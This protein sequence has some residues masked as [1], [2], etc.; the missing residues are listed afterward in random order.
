MFQKALRVL[1]IED[2]PDDVLL[3]RDFLA[4]SPEQI[5]ILH[6]E[7]L[8]EALESLDNGQT[9]VDAVLLD[10]G[11]P[12]TQG[13]ETFNQ[14]RRQAPRIP[15]V[16][17]TGM[18]DEE[19]ASQAVRAGAQDYLVKGKVNGQLL[20]RALY[21]AVERKKYEEAL[22]RA[23]DELESRVQ[24]RTSELHLAN[25][26]LTKLFNEL[27]HAEQKVRRS[28]QGIINVVSMIIEARDPYT[29]GHQKAV[30]EIAGAVAHRMG[31]PEERIEGIRLAATVHDL[32]KIS[33]P[34]EILAKPTRLSEIE[35][36]II[37]LHPQSGY[38]ILKLVD[39]PW[40]IA[41]IVLQHHERIDGSGYPQGLT[42]ADILLEAK[43]IGVADVVEAMCSH[44]PYRPALGIDK[45]LQE[46]LQNKGVLY[47]P[48][49]VDA[50]LQYFAE[51]RSGSLTNIAGRQEK[52][53]SLPPPPPPHR[54]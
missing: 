31:L 52:L 53:A 54:F 16:V 6:C 42:A 14:V 22:L 51:K 44:R 23:Q 11:L 13:L 12:D 5:E 45:A 29:A 46:I 9:E 48:H 25:E 43:I 3:L 2:N 1:L 35:M 41:Q 27:S 50:C 20:V 17:L 40:P 28:L 10:L 15:I 24:E 7:R 30:T 4:K 38:E 34:A 19:L 8:A 49:V 32:G 39:F 36:G 21:Y 18:D 33:I 47:D 26:T 37:R